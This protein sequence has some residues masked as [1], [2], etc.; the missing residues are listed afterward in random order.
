M[1]PSRFESERTSPW[2]R[3]RSSRAVPPA[4]TPIREERSSSSSRARS[5]FTEPSVASARPPRTARGRHSSS[6]PAKWTRSSTRAPS[7]TSFSSPSRVCLRATPRELT[8]RTPAPARVS[9]DLTKRDGPLRQGPSRYA[10]SAG[11]LPAGQR[12]PGHLARLPGLVGRAA[13]L[14]R[15]VRGV[16]IGGGFQGLPPLKRLPSSH[17]A[18]RVRL[19]A[20][21]VC[22]LPSSAHLPSAAPQSTRLRRTLRRFA[23][24]PC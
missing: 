9:D 5:P 22:A 3:S 19:E 13:R 17:E 2:H 4:G 16:G 15:R 23:P 20:R 11:G 7:H 21:L 14:L 6:D 18:Q 10:S 12:A 24:V 1:G 8:S